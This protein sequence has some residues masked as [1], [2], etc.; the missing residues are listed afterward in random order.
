MASIQHRPNFL[1]FRPNLV[2]PYIDHEVVTPSDLADLPLA[3]EYG[4]A[5]ALIWSG[6]VSAVAITTI[7]GDERLIDFWP[8]NTLL[9]Y[10]VVRVRATGTT[11]TGIVALY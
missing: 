8:L 6:G 2:T 10:Q 3:A 4:C 11:A 1:Q 9:Q 7:N 5:R